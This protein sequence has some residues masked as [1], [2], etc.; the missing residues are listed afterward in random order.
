MLPP[1]SCFPHLFNDLKTREF[2][3]KTELDTAFDT[4]EQRE[5]IRYADV[6]ISRNNG[7]VPMKLSP[8]GFSLTKF[9]SYLLASYLYFIINPFL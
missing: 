9:F 3:T 7:E 1:Q 6:C 5:Y 2:R 4:Y 8:S